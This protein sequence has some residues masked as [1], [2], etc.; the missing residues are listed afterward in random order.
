MKIAV[1][2]LTR[3]LKELRGDKTVYNTELGTTLSEAHEVEEKLVYELMLPRAL[4]KSGAELILVRGIESEVRFRSVFARVVDKAE[5]KAQNRPNTKRKVDWDYV[6]KLL[7]GKKPEKPEIPTVSYQRKKTRIFALENSCFTFNLGGRRVIT[8]PADFPAENAEE[9]LRKA[10]KA[11]ADNAE[12]FP[13][14]YSLSERTLRVLSFPQRHLPIK[15]DPKSEKIRKTVMLAAMLVFVVAAGMFIQN[16]FI[17]PMQ[18]EQLQSQIRTLAFEDE[19]GS[20][21]GLTAK[22]K[23]T[24]NWKNLKKTNSEIVAWVQMNNTKIDNPVV[25]HKG[26]NEDAQFYYHRDV[27]KNYSDYGTLYIDY[28]SKKSVDSKNVIIHGHHMDDGSMF[29]E[30]L[31]YGRYSG[32]LGFYK[33]TPTFTLYTQKGGAQTYKIISV[34]KSNVDPAQGE[35]FDFYNGS[36]KSDLQ[37]MNYVYN[38][39]VRSLINCPVSVNEDDKLVTLVTCSYEFVHGRN[40]FRT[41]VVARKCRKGETDKVDTASAS[42]NKHPVWPQCY[43]NRYG[44]TRPTISD[45]K[46]EYKKGN[47]SWYDGSGKL[48]GSQQLPTSL[49]PTTEPTTEPTTV[50]ATTSPKE[51]T[52]KIKVTSRGKKLIYKR[53]KVGTVVK[54]PKIKSFKKSGYKYT[55]RRWKTRGFSKTYLSKDVTSV[56]VNTTVVLKAEFKKTKIKKP[57]KTPK[58]TKPKATK[59]TKPATKPTTKATKPTTKPATKPAEPTEP[60]TAAQETTEPEE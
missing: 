7:T 4:R 14:G 38:L 19:G 15:S 33:K 57:A 29:A 59:A 30:L 23:K 5:Q 8:V 56:K 45:F 27:N 24:V 10:E 16:M 13:D 25:F 53:V 31:K 50:Q 9:L 1:F 11:F 44:G 40:T 52:Y 20:S 32:D 26:D 28:R 17:A 60:P 3:S 58:A 37:F 2:T 22:K 6:K 18:N 48:K 41:V 43:Y 36:F 42:L 49:K 12:S 34:F 51:R 47:L 54:L 21:P 55:L 39:R 35:Y 46:T